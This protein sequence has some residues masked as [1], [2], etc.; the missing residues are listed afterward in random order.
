MVE[1]H[2]PSLY[3][4]TSVQPD[5]TPSVG[6]TVWMAEII[7]DIK[8]HAAATASAAGG[9]VKSVPIPWAGVEPT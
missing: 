3:P 8:A 4:H 7:N 6:V 1:F 5:F 2:L 9:R